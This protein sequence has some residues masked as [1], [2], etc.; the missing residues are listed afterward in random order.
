MQREFA[1]YH[2]I[3]NCIFFTL[4]LLVTMLLWH[5]LMLSISFF[6]AFFY[7][8][9]LYGARQALSKLGLM[10]PFVL[11]TALINLFLNHRGSTVLLYITPKWP[12]TA[13]AM[14]FGVAS[15][16]MLLSVVLWSACAAQIITGERFIYLFGR[17]FSTIALIFSMTLG[18]VPRF[19]ARFAEV[20]AAQKLLGRSAAQ[21]SF[22]SRIQAGAKTLSA[23]TTW[24]FEAAIVTADS[25]RSRGYGTGKRTS[26]SIYRIQRRDC[27]AWIFFALAAAVIVFCMAKGSLKFQFYDTLSG[28]YGAWTAAG[29]GVYFCLCNFPLLICFLEEHQWR[30]TK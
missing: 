17:R 22:K 1:A 2:P 5:P 29:A 19:G 23:V 6:S 26:F 15:A 9:H 16:V 3:T 28:S 7:A 24:M 13:E 20:S 4:V 21:G 27:F 12:V 18:L 10:L 14:L 30:H 25:M 11:I 8:L